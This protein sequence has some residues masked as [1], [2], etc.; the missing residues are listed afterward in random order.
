LSAEIRDAPSTK[1]ARTAFLD[2][3]SRNKHIRWSERGEVRRHIKVN[4]SFPGEL[5]ADVT[6]EY[7]MVTGGEDKSIPPVGEESPMTIGEIERGVQ[8]VGEGI[9][10][11]VEG[12]GPMGVA[13]EEEPGDMTEA[14]LV[15]P[16][17]QPMPY[18]SFPLPSPSVYPEGEGAAVEVGGEEDVG[19]QEPERTLG[20][21]P[22]ARLSRKSGGM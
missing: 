11:G 12:V 18:R 14:A 5:E 2:Y 4:K 8:G 6:L 20:N 10:E 9:S 13:A 1:R 19:P 16:R 15:A 22:I 21:S 3:L 7:D 17:R